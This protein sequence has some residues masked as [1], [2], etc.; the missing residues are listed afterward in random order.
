VSALG[1]KR[2]CHT[3]KEKAANQ[4]LE[5]KQRAEMLS[6]L[7]PSKT[8]LRKQLEDAVRNTAVLPAGETP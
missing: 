3:A 4:K 6:S 2:R 5:R 7:E 1:F 8:D